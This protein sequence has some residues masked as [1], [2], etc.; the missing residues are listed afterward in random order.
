M[1]LTAATVLEELQRRL[2]IGTAESAIS[3]ANIF[4]IM[5]C[6]QCTLNYAFDRS[7]STGTFTPASA[8]TLY[9]TT[10]SIHGG[11]FRI[12]TIYESTRTVMFVPNWKMLQQYDRN[13]FRSAGTRTEAWAPVGHNMLAIYPG[14]TTALG[15]TYVSRP[16]AITSSGDVFKLPAVDAPLIYDLCEIVLLAHLRLYPEITRKLQSFQKAVEPYVEREDFIR[17]R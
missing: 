14:S 3:D 1:A 12:L 8:T 17:G 6:V 5:D 7:V 10:T 11:C 13:W 15:V 2:R 9:A 16:T 4:T